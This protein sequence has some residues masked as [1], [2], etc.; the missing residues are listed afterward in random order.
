MIF[1]EIAK[2]WGSEGGNMRERNLVR[3]IRVISRWLKEQIS[4]YEMGNQ[5]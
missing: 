2:A 3:S 1:S 4:E 5:V